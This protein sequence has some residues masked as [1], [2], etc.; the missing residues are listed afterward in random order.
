M[1]KSDIKPSCHICNIESNYLLSKDGFDLYK[2]TKCGLV[3]VYP[4]ATQEFLSKKIYSIES[5]FQSNRAEALKDTKLNKRSKTVLQWILKYKS[6]ASILDVGCGGGHFLYWLSKNNLQAEGIELNKRLSDSANEQGLKVFNG[7]LEES[8]YSDKSFDLV[9]LGEVIEH[10]PNPRNLLLKCGQLLKDDGSLVITTPNINC[11]WSK[12]TYFFYKFFK[13]PWSSITPP[14]HLYQ[15][16]N[17]NLDLLL[18]DIGFKAQE[19]WYLPQPRLTY[20]L[21]SLHLLKRYKK[22]ANILNLSFM[23]FAFTVYTISHTLLL[24]LSPFLRKNF[25]MVKIYSRRTEKE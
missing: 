16:D 7:I 10:V 9:Y 12:I 8:H 13:I 2:C 11:L 24:L 1:V 21:G 5:G 25:S 19:E 22:N 3:F 6:N 17:K 18:D 15:F 4:L 14:Y 20:E 23:I